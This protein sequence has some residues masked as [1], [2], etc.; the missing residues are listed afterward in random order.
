MSVEVLEKPATAQPGIVALVGKYLEVRDKKKA[1][2]EA[3]K[4]KMAKVNELLTRIE[5]A[6]LEQF[7][8]EGIDS[9][10]TAKGTAYISTTTSV[11]VAD[12]DEVLDFIR[13]KEAWHMLERR[14]SKGAVEQWQ[15]EY[16][17]LPPGLNIRM[18][19]KVNVRQK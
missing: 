17:E 14:V 9:V 6:L 5:N 2:D 12:W 15:D 10:R 7:Q 19:R 18:E 1:L 16:G 4:Q 8:A 11:S 13:E 3:H